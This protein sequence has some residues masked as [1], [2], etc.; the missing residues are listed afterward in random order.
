MGGWEDQ[1]GLPG[2]TEGQASMGVPSRSVVLPG[3]EAVTAGMGLGLGWGGTFFQA[4]LWES[5]DI[6]AP[7]K[8]IPMSFNQSPPQDERKTW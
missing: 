4:H 6:S 2:L 3:E 1:P 5:G 8:E 7:V